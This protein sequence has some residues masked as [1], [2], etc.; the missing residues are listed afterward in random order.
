M[1][2]LFSQWMRELDFNTINNTGIPSIVLMENA[3]RG[4]A[5]VIKEQFP[6]EKFTN[7][8]ILSG[9][10]NNGGDGIATGRILA[11]WGYNPHFLFLSDPGT[12]SGDPL[13]NFNIINELG[14]KWTFVSDDNYIQDF[15]EDHSHCDTIIIDAI[16][17]TGMK[18]P[19]KEGIYH[20][21]IK[22]LNRSDFKIVSIDLPSGLSDI[23]PPS[24]GY[25]VEPDVTVSFQS[26]KIAHIFPDDRKRCGEIF[27]A[28]IGIPSVYIEDKKYFINLSEPSDF[29][30][31][32][33][34]RDSGMHKGNLGH[35]L[36]VAGS[37]DKPGASIL[38]S[39]SVLR[40][41]AGLS[42]CVASEKNRDL[43][44][45]AYPEIMIRDER[46]FFKIE[47]IPEEYDCILAGPGMGIEENSNELIKKILSISDVPVVLDADALNL[48]EGNVEILKSRREYPLILTPHPKEFSRISGETIS[49]ILADPVNS[50]RDFAMEY[51]LFVVLKGHYSL[52]A[53]PD[54]QVIINQTGNP[55]MATAGSG[56]VLGG[57]ITGMIAQFHRKF[58]ILKILQA[59]VFIH[60]YAGDIAASLKGESPMIASD[61]IDNIY[62]AAGKINEYKSE[63]RFT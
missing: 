62:N 35:G 8:I 30:D 56:D 55:G 52:I 36:V 21:I 48:M 61:I 17:G 3:S 14:L 33:V 58:S 43:I 27:V 42:T 32:S 49:E 63:F 37:D 50:A 4:S 7:I 2:V 38:S 26:L 53:S 20:E 6:V 34:K 31:L 22:Y 18:R 57:I 10:G 44:M 1:K 16:F 25:Y 15:L 59:A 47:K 11:Q 12:F 54:G 23:F 39:I 9:P 24:D 41:G 45:K 5:Q 19:V 28:D 29:A 46:E 40:S 51:D 13:I 60:G